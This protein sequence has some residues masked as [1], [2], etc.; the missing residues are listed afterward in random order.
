[1]CPACIITVAL[2]IASTTSTGGVTA[3]VVKKLRA[4]T[5]AKSI[6]APTQTSG[7][8]DGSSKSRVASRVVRRNWL[9]N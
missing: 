6:D 8:Q 3:L 2:T 4:K 9:L 5:G 1:M 7:S